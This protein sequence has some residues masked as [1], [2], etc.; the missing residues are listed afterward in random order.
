MSIYVCIADGDILSAYEVVNKISAQNT[1]IVVLPTEVIYISGID[2]RLESSQHSYEIW[3]NQIMPYPNDKD[4]ECAYRDYVL[5]SNYKSEYIKSVKIENKL[6]KRYTHFYMYLYIYMKMYMSFTLWHIYYH[7]V[8]IF[9]C[10]CFL[11][12]ESRS[13]EESF[14]KKPNTF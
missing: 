8:N 6:S 12:D 9:I 14:N 13:T 10:I 2:F 5:W 7:P 11:R 3:K 1:A 4:I